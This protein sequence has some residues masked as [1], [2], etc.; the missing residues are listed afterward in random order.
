MEFVVVDSGVTGSR[1]RPDTIY[2]F[3]DA[4]DDWFAFQ[5]RFSVVY[6]TSDGV[7]SRIGFT[8][9]G[10][11]GLKPARE[12]EEARDGYRRPNPPRTFETLPDNF[13]SLGQDA[14]FYE[15]LGK[16]G[17]DFRERVLAALR[18]LAFDKDLLVRAA[19]EEVTKVSLL[20][21]IPIPTVKDQFARVARGGARLT[22]YNFSFQTKGLSI[23]FDVEPNSKPPTNIHVLVGRNGVGKSTMLN[24]M[25]K[26]FVNAARKNADSTDSGRRP[27]SV[28]SVTNV[29]LVSFS[30]F[31]V[32]EPITVPRDR[33]KSVGYHY[34]GIKKIN[35]K[36]DEEQIKDSPALSRE[37][38]I[39]AK[40]CLQG[41]GRLR[42]LR[43][44]RLLEGD[45]IFGRIGLA[46]LAATDEEEFFSDLPEIFK[47]LSS[48]HKIILLTIT[49]LVETVVEK[50]VVFLDEPEAHLHP[51]LLSA[52]VRALSDLLTNRNGLAIIATH[53]PVVLQEVPRSCAWRLQRVGD[54]LSAERL[55]RETFGENV[56]TLTDD[57]FG[58]EV[59][60]TGFHKMLSDLAQESSTYED[61]IAELG[62]QL[63]A[64][65]RAILRAKMAALRLR[66]ANVAR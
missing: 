51:P 6:I 49:R 22:P 21:D 7:R 38:T 4:W 65:G 35:P 55:E 32:F 3:P 47:K 48:G 30:A 58:L 59:T 26:A 13:F 8:K 9:I 24:S 60:A 39:S 44:I 52:F 12:A 18:D 27:G 19:T 43:A 17:D 20:R 23:G 28:Q 56:G 36:K 29:V 15:A 64:E 45:P 61:A 57:V 31:D 66:G 63:G 37:M 33:T 1:D 41:T 62:G 16:I 11:F 2:L 54:K 25:A 50:T 10:R 42:W 40:N 34:I 5:T 14:S 53:S 46:D